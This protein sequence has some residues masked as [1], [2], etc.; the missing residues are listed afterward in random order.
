VFVVSGLKAQNYIRYCDDFIVTHHDWEYLEKLI[1]MIRDFLR[2]ELKL[3]LHPK[4]VKIIKLH[5]GVDFLGY[6][7]FSRHLILRTKTKKRMLKKLKVKK[8]QLDDGTITPE[9]FNQS[10]QSYLGILKHCSGHKIRQNLP[11]LAVID[12]KARNK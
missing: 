4:K 9:A 10:L 2:Q 7:T 3:D 6:V 1:P 11:P 5:R 8:Q 12:K